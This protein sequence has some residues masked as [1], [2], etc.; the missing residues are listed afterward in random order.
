MKHCSNCRNCVTDTRA[1]LLL[2]IY[3]KKCRLG[4]QRILHPFFSGLKCNK[5]R[6]RKNNAMC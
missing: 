2:G 6:R 3:I 1:L 5:Y 4:G